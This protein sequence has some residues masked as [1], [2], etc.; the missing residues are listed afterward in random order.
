[1]KLD[2]FSHCAI[3][4][5]HINDTN[6]VV[7]GGAGC[8]CSLIAKTLKFD[9]ILHTKFG[10]DFPLVEYLSKENILIENALSEKL[11]KNF[12]FR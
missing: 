2:I 10:S 11:T 12:I 1:M 8:Y 6:Y 4:T 9:V 5:I 7:P 3:D